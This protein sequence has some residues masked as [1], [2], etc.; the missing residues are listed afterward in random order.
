MDLR[1]LD[2]A[3]PVE[4]SPKKEP[5]G[6]PKSKSAVPLIVDSAQT[7]S[8]PSITANPQV[9]P[10]PGPEPNPAGN[11][12]D[13]GGSTGTGGSKTPGTE[14]DPTPMPDEPPAFEG[15]LAALTRFIGQN[16]SYP[17]LAKEMGKEGKVY[18]S[19]VVNE[20]GQ[21]ERVKLARGIGG[22]CDEE[23]MRVVSK[24]PKFKSPGKVKGKAVKVLFNVPI[25]F[26]LK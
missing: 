2:K 18:V 12:P 8:T 19:F 1:K 21:V 25:V 9:N 4:S 3:K 6:G 23:A 14:D 11:G 15:G 10:N 24:I 20:M 5:S 17:E 13:T 22:G 26:K 7:V 16:I